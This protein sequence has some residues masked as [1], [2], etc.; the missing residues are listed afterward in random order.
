[1]LCLPG[2]N[3]ELL[4][5]QQSSLRPVFA[6]QPSNQLNLMPLFL[7]TIVGLRDG[8]TI[9][10]QPD[11]AGFLSFGP[12]RTIAPGRYGI[13]I[14][15]TA[16]PCS[17]AVIGYWDVVADSVDGELARG[18][19]RVDQGLSVAEGVFS[20][21]AEL[22]KLEIRTFYAGACSFQLQGITLTR[23]N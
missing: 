19:I 15:F 12:Y 20:S 23:L 9:V 10:A 8:N 18:N 7:P 6:V 16:G 1:M 21:A 2:Q 5:Q 3:A 14:K 13:T 4:A 11:K 17:Q 22:E